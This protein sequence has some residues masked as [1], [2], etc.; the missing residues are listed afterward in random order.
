MEQLTP[1]ASQENL[2]PSEPNTIGHNL[3][4]SPI[5]PTFQFSN[6]IRPR[7]P[8]TITPRSFTRFF[9]PKSSIKRNS[10]TGSS[11][12]ILRD[13]TASGNNRRG[14]R[15]QVKGF[16]SLD[17][18]VYSES[19]LRAKRRR[20]LPPTP[21]LTPDF[22][23]PLKRQGRPA[24][25][26]TKD[27]DSDDQEL[28]AKNRSDGIRLRISESPRRYTPPP[29]SR[30]K[31]T[32][33][34]GTN[35]LVAIADEDGGIKLLESAGSAKDDFSTPFLQFRP[36]TN[37]ILDV[38]FTPDDMLIA[39]ASGDQTALVIDMPS[40]KA[41]Y[42]MAGH[43]SS[44]KQVRF[45]P[46]NSSVIVTSSRDGSVQIW[47]LRCKGYD[48]PVKEIKVALDGVPVKGVAPNT[49]LTWGR[50]VNTIF[51]AHAMRQSPN[52]Q[53]VSASGTNIDLP[54]KSECPGRKGDVSV[55]VLTFLTHGREHLLATGSE[56]DACV[57]LWDLRTTHNHRRGHAT[58]LSTTQQSESHSRYRRFGLT[59]FSLSDDGARLYA[60][61]R[62]NTV[63]TYSTSHLVLGHAPELT[64]ANSKPRRSGGQEKVGM[65]PMYGF[66]H[67][68][69]HATTFYIKSSIRTARNDNTELLA[70]GSSDGAPVLFPTDERYMQRSA[71]PDPRMQREPSLPRLRPALSRTE[72]GTDLSG[73]LEDSIPIY[74]HGTAL[75]RGHNCEVTGLDWTLNGDLVSVGD[76]FAVR[77]W[78]EGDSPHTRQSARHMRMNGEK[79]GKRWGCGW[80]EVTDGW[81]DDDSDI[82]D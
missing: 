71:N 12:Q 67:P 4:S 82:S 7:K 74:H 30:S 9:T 10:K 40:Q 23:S 79:G 73:R 33:G 54:S 16:I 34:P 70:V 56:A 45:Q 46:T 21:A 20:K 78:R 24:S 25:G 37:A 48:G 1:A 14:G 32:T 42:A 55:T 15:G 19:A 63:Y 3:D 11:R 47:D 29:F 39:T 53:S 58:P 31:F 5:L 41:T 22:S 76:D 52:V 49:K 2:P 72:S 66:R 8:P 65:G 81:D 36:H 27:E 59:S 6:P 60:A 35:S 57:K 43:V 68:K 64:S 18:D 28:S 13:I 50:S 69:F 38:D 26:C 44:V 62:D 77:C 80:A 61:C 51:D 75:V 17:D